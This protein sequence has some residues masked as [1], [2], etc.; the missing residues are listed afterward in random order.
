MNHT[1]SARTTAIHF[2][3][4]MALERLELPKVPGAPAFIALHLTRAGANIV[5]D[6]AVGP[7]HDHRLNRMLGIASIKH[8]FPN[9]RCRDR[10]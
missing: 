4:T 3:R 7:L 5:F 8:I 6:F 9:P 1:T 10:R 2:L